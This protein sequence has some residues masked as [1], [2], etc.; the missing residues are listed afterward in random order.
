VDRY[1]VAT[2][3]LVSGGD[4]DTLS[5][6]KAMWVTDFEPTMR[7]MLPAVFGRQTRPVAWD[8]VAACLADS[9]DR[10]QVIVANGSSFYV[11]VRGLPLDAAECG[12][13]RFAIPRLPESAWINA[14][15]IMRLP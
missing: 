11:L 2:R 10:I 5:R 1:L 12:H 4:R 15:R 9:S 3:A 13:R 6:L 14:L 8:D 7:G